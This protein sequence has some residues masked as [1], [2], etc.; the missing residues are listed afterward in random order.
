MTTPDFIMVAHLISGIITDRGG[1]VCHAAILAREFDI[2]CIVGCQ[3][4]TTTI[5]DGEQIRL[6]AIS[7]IV[8]SVIQ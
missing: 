2:P 4:A 5:T 6:D 8:V 1:V 3:T 7:G